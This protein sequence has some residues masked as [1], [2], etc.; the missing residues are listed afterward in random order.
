MNVSAQSCTG[1]AAPSA[2]CLYDVWTSDALQDAKAHAL[3]TVDGLV[4]VTQTAW[5]FAFAPRS[6]LMS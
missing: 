4:S 3:S 6:R 5:G 2:L 1:A